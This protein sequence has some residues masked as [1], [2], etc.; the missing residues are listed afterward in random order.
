MYEWEAIEADGK[1]KPGRDS[2]ARFSKSVSVTVTE[3]NRSFRH[4]RYG[5]EVNSQYESTSRRHLLR[6]CRGNCALDGRLSD[7]FTRG[8]GNTL[9]PVVWQDYTYALVIITCCFTGGC[10]VTVNQESIKTEFGFW[11]WNQFL[12]M[13]ARTLTDTIEHMTDSEAIHLVDFELPM[14][15]SVI[16]SRPFRPRSC[17]DQGNPVNH[18]I[19]RLR[20]Q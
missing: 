7:A 6:A 18:F 11:S 4:I 5:D 2:R 16:P 19:R 10:Q 17:C 15:T 8:P 9:W 12:A 14:M 1:R 20:T 3:R 13:L